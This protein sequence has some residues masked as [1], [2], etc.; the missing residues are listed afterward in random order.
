MGRPRAGSMKVPTVRRGVCMG[1]SAPNLR[2]FSGHW[3]YRIRH[4][5]DSG[6]WVDARLFT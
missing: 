5:K 4:R 1:S 2:A 6:V 3:L